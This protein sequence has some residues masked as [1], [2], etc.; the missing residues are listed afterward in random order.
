MS[1]NYFLYFANSIFILFCST[2]LLNS[3]PLQIIK[4]RKNCTVNV[5]VLDSSLENKAIKILFGQPDKESTFDSTII[6]IDKTKHSKSF[7]LDFSFTD[8][9]LSYF[10][11][12]QTIEEDNVQAIFST[13]FYLLQKD[14]VHLELSDVASA[15]SN[16]SFNNDRNNSINKITKAIEV[17]IF[18]GILR[19]EDYDSLKN[20][21]FNDLSYL[22]DKFPDIG[23]RLL[24]K[25]DR[26][27]FQ[28]SIDNIFFKIFFKKVDSL[29][30]FKKRNH[31]IKILNSEIRPDSLAMDFLSQSTDSSIISLK[32][33][34]GSYL[35][36]DFW[37]SW[38]DPCRIKNRYLKENY[39]DLSVLGFKF[40]SVSIDESS[41]AWKK[42]LTE[43]DLPWD[44]SLIQDKKQ[45]EILDNF[46]RLN[47][48]PYTILID[49]LGRV[50]GLN[51]SITQIKNVLKKKK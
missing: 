13:T 33:Y 14:T 15:T 37:A 47:G 49:P 11:L 9:S 26:I 43:D 4:E 29:A 46:Y 3:K 25:Y 32:N 36:L 45:K 40:L 16:L 35:L 24:V 30:T 34:R 48:I 50:I 18:K 5:S 17:N 10:I 2:S 7:K 22:L 51:P 44:N 23:L 6:F 28:D 20:L 21:A 31:F 41:S 8:S 12:F 1:T 19:E 42:I 39:T 27:G 38:C